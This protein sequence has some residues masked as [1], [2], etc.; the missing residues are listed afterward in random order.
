MFH[1]AFQA[2]GVLIRW[3]HL[4]HTVCGPGFLLCAPE[5]YCY[6]EEYWCDG[7]PDCNGDIVE[8]ES[9]CISEWCGC[10]CVIKL[11][12]SNSGNNSMTDLQR[13]C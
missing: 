1:Y 12:D 10:V 5:R 3:L 13:D 8:D 7:I 9:N 4:S 11:S 2:L 6:P